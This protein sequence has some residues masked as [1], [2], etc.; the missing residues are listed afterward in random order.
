MGGPCADFEGELCVGLGREEIKGEAVCTIKKEE[1][2][3]KKQA[4]KGKR[5]VRNEVREERKQGAREA[6]SLELLITSSKRRV[7]KQMWYYGNRPKQLRALSQWQKE[8]GV[9]VCAT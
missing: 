3:A 8:H 5:E 7:Q 9:A 1:G 4:A 6:A 2:K